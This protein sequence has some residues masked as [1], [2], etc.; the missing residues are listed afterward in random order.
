M[1]IQTKKRPLPPS[2]QLSISSSPELES[3]TTKTNNNLNISVINEL[4][5]ADGGGSSTMYYSSDA[6]GS[7]LSGGVSSY[8]SSSSESL[9]S[10]NNINNNNNNNEKSTSSI[11]SVSTYSNRSNTIVDEDNNDASKT[12]VLTPPP[13]VPLTTVYG[14]AEIRQQ[15][16][17]AAVTVS[18]SRHFSAAAKLCAMSPLNPFENQVNL[19]KLEIAEV[20]IAYFS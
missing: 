16:A 11:S 18:L 9:N 6:F 7:C 14:P 15:A 8:V 3:T 10:H 20:F 5:S 13:K 4:K 2:S 1:D 19:T 17:A 12:S